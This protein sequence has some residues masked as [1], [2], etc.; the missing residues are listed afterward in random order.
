MCPPSSWNC[1]HCF[2]Q[3]GISR[4]S[5]FFFLVLN[6]NFPCIL[7]YFFK[8]YPFNTTGF[9]YPLYVLPES[10]NVSHDLGHYRR[11]DWVMKQRI[12]HTY[13]WPF[14][15]SVFSETDDRPAWLAAVRKYLWP[16]FI[17]VRH[18]RQNSKVCNSSYKCLYEK[19][20][21]SAEGHEKMVWKYWSEKTESCLHWVSRN[22]SWFLVS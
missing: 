10:R 22:G 18:L 9:P 4:P 6:S 17:F 3:L 7:F 15:L 2:S 1:S 21:K 5:I 11:M 16:N 14:W 20:L 8:Y 19:A 12:K 13:F